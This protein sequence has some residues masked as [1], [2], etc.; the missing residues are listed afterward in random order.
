MSSA[1]HRLPE[2]V[3]HPT[4]PGMVVADG[5]RVTDRPEVWHVRSSTTAYASPFIDVVLDEVE[6]PQGGAMHRTTVRH[7]AAVGVV[8]LDD[9]GRVL[10]L[11]QYRHPVGA[12]LVELPAGLLD[13]DGEPA[14]DAAARELAEEADLVASR[15][16]PLVTLRS[17]PGF[18]DER[19]EVFLA[20]G[21]SAVAD[22]A[23]TDRVDEEADMAAVWVP[24]EDAVAAVLDGRITNSLAVAGLLACHIRANQGSSA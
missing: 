1:E 6:T 5:A 22:D 7:D 15:W 16:E 21:L 18:T 17:S 24:L 13:I 3:P 14:Q 23:R 10:L 9:D 4:L 11:E 2:R 8:V 12:R 20:R 19:V